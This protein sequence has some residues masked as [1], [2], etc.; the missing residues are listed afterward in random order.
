MES[1]G[2]LAFSNSS[3]VSFSVYILYITPIPIHQDTYREVRKSFKILLEKLNQILRI[4]E[5][6]DARKNY[7]VVN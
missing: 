7:S 5:V 3:H 2:N 1:A 6:K 4:Q